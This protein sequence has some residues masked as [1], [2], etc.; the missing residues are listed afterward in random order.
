VLRDMLLNHIPVLFHKEIYATACIVGGVCY[1]FS[2]QFM[3]QQV[4][5]A[6]SVVLICTI[7]ILAVRNNWRL[8]T[9]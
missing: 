9:V 6:I 5:E 2:L 4:A 7:R 3:E 1:I 8:P